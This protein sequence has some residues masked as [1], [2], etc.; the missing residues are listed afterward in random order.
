M[1]TLQP[2]GGERREG[3]KSRG[4]GGLVDGSGIDFLTTAAAK[5]H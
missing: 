4:G 1:D 3:K 2:E 5:Q